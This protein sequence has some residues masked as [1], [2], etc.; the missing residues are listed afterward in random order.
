MTP[1]GNLITKSGLVAYFPP[2]LSVKNHVTEPKAN[3]DFASHI[4]YNYGIVKNV[5][6]TSTTV[7]LELSFRIHHAAPPMSRA[8]VW[9]ALNN[10]TLDLRISG[11][12]FNIGENVTLQ[13]DYGNVGNTIFV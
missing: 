12:S 8:E 1:V 11:N 3:G 6:S 5:G 13:I 7:E 9:A 10:S 2:E 4:E